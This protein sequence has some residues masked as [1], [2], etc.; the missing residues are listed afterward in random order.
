[1]SCFSFN[2]C[3]SLRFRNIKLSWTIH[4]SS[5]H[6]CKSLNIILRGAGCYTQCQY[7]LNNSLLQF[8]ESLSV[9]DYILSWITALQNLIQ[10]RC[11]TPCSE[12]QLTFLEFLM[13]IS[14]GNEPW[15]WNPIEMQKFDCNLYQKSHAMQHSVLHVKNL[16]PSY[17]IGKHVLRWTNPG[18]YCNIFATG[19]NSSC[20]A[21][22]IYA[23][24]FFDIIIK[25]CSHSTY[26]EFFHA[27]KN[28]FVSFIRWTNL[29]ETWLLYVVNWNFYWYSR[30]SLVSILRKENTERDTSRPPITLSG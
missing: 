13:I 11:E 8:L 12:D 26:C 2:W 23:W 19:W 22:K 25:C 1:M 24:Q 17:H 18:D 4:N 14:P 21:L 29:H 20:K 5:L 30:P 10:P 9:R 28:A 15:W 16:R 3:C 7:I 27:F 6:L